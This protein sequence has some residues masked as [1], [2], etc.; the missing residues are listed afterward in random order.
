[1]Q[2]FPLD[3]Y[4]QK[5]ISSGLLSPPQCAD[6][7]RELALDASIDSVSDFLVK[8]RLLTPFQA[9]QIASGE[10][11]LVLGQYHILDEIGR[12]GCGR[13]FKARHTLMGRVVAL[14][15]I[16]PGVLQHPH[17][18]SSFRREVLATT[19]LIHP[20][21]VMAYDANEVDET[22]FFVMEYVDGMN[23]HEFVKKH[24]PLPFRMA[25]ELLM[26]VAMGLQYAHEQGLVHRDIK[27]PNLLIPRQAHERLISPARSLAEAGVPPVLVKILDFGL[28]R[29]SS[30]IGEAITPMHSE[31][32]FRGTPEF[33]SPEQARNSVSADI[34]SDLYSLGCTLYY[35]LTGRAPFQGSTALEIVV[36]HFEKTARP[37]ESLRP[38][39]PAL[40]ASI[41]RR[42]MAKDPDKRFQTPAELI[43][44][45]RFFLG[46][47]G[48]ESVEKDAR[49]SG[50]LAIARVP[51]VEANPVASE[52][53]LP[54][55]QDSPLSEQL[56]ETELPRVWPRP[57]GTDP[58]PV[59]VPTR[60]PETVVVRPPAE[61]ASESEA[62]IESSHTFAPEPAT[63]IPLS[64]LWQNWL[65]VADGEATDLNENDYRLL[66]GALLRA[67]H[68]E[69]E[70]STGRRQERLR[71][72]SAL[73]QPWVNLD[74]LSQTDTV[75]RADLRS[76]CREFAE[77]LGLSS[78]GWSWGL[79]LGVLAL[80]VVS[81][82][83]AAAVTAGG[84]L[85]PTSV[86]WRTVESYWRAHPILSLTVL[87]PIALTVVMVTFAF[88][89]RRG[90]S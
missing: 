39:T 68:V 17:A 34:R 22:L 83:V 43:A 36:Q 62:P 27:P 51:T 90:V 55:T 1:V 45:V 65:A 11:K 20:N 18:R 28:A 77:S 47:R 80:V 64:T 87:V 40:L 74:A 85:N 29:V 19:R 88:T 3:S 33:V 13:V 48:S 14:K 10:M 26:Q 78:N 59:D 15:V 75:T 46:S 8:R 23:L 63:D 52:S 21:I 72:L 58:A 76:R 70:N 79:G 32:G 71:R 50:H 4:V 35:A 16:G 66:H 25:S 24:G 44:E 38:E 54:A 82:V 61:L 12:G 84:F 2:A 69:A 37:V 5:V 89:R 60:M 49:A 30:T 57:V 56:L 42:L 81:A 86:S 31:H 9:E 6:I 73:V 53:N 67:L 41:V 7:S